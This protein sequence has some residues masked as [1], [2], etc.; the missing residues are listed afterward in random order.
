MR[1]PRFLTAAVAATL[2][3]VGSAPSDDPKPA[4]PAAK[5]KKDERSPLMAEKLKHAQALLEGL[6]TN[7]FARITRSGKELIRI[8]RTTEL[9]AKAKNRQY[10]LQLNTFREAVERVIK[11]GGEKNLDGAT[12]GYVDMTLACVRCHQLTREVRDARLTLPNPAT[13]G[14]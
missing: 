6:T 14:R 13:A 10:E 1:A 12:L 9:T 5:E 4:P 11:K 3:G 7:D 2:I 8:S